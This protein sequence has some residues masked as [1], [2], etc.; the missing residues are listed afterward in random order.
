[1]VALIGMLASVGCATRT[2]TV[3]AVKSDDVTASGD[4]FV[5]VNGNPERDDDD[6]MVRAAADYVRTALSSKGKYEAPANVDPHIVVEVDFG[7][8]A[9]KSEVIEHQEAIYRTVRSP[10]TYVTETYTDE[11]GKTR[12]VV[13]YIPGEEREEFAGWQTHRIVLTVYPK[14]LR[15]T[16]RSVPEEGDDG[17]PRELWSVYVTNEDGEQSMSE[18][19]P[20]L[21]AAAMDAMDQNASSKRTISLDPDDERV[22]FVKRGM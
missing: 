1:M 7:S 22:V 17:P 20:L 15:I 4:G 19:L 3:D 14:Y 9:P 18:T 6:A 10:G 13:R 16:A 11:N 12:T 2:F 8:E 21:V 5:V